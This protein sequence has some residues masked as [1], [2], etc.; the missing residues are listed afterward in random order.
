M[1]EE[2]VQS[3][4]FRGIVMVLVILKPYVVFNAQPVLSQ[5]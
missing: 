4:C 1:I 3:F 2:V 5:F